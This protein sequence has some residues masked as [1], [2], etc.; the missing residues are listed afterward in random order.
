MSWFVAALAA[1][2]GCASVAGPVWVAVRLRG[3][4]PSWLGY[5]VLVAAWALWSAAVQTAPS[6]WLG[7][8]LPPGFV[9]LA[10]GVARVLSTGHPGDE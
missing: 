1:A 5:P 2:A 9:A 4:R 10:A 7:V 6:P 8:L 3:R